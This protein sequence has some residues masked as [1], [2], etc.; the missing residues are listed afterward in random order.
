MTV[1]GPEPVVREAIGVSSG[2]AIGTAFVIEPRVSHLYEPL[3]PAVLRLLEQ[4]VV[5]AQ[6]HGVPVSLCGEAASDPLTAM[7]FLGY[8]IDELSMTPSSVPVIK[9]LIRSLPASDAR[10]ILAHAMELRT[11]QEVEEFA[12]E[13]LMA[14]LPEGYEG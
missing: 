10:Q 1:S 2:V 3:H 12:L 5:R 13:Q 9:S 14:H 11:A 4:I 7:V 8:G 6:E